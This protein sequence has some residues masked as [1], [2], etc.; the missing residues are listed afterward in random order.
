MV[1]STVLSKTGQTYKET[2]MNQAFASGK[3]FHPEMYRYYT[4][5]EFQDLLKPLTNFKPGPR[6][7]CVTPNFR[8]VDTQSGMSEREFI[9]LLGGEQE[10]R[11]NVFTPFEVAAIVEKMQSPLVGNEQGNNFFVLGDQD[12]LF[13]VSV[14]Q[15]PH[16]CLVDVHP[17][18]P[19]TVHGGACRLF[20][21][22][23]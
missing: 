16:E 18:K 14:S 9:L 11:K 15:R 1:K 23:K 6:P 7:L 4:W 2:T 13:L 20:R 12:Q 19:N 3:F 17:H 10:V 21:K 8:H 5:S 22:V